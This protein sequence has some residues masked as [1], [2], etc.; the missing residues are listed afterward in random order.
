VSEREPV[1]YWARLVSGYQE[2]YSLSLSQLAQA[3]GVDRSAVVRW[4]NGT[5]IPSP[6]VKRILEDGQEKAA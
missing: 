6:R 1:T 5:R 4:K 2:A 3:L